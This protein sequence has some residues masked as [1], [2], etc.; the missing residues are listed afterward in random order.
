MEDQ[1]TSNYRFGF[2]GKGLPRRM[3]RR[4]HGRRTKPQRS[5]DSAAARSPSTRKTSISAATF[6]QML[7]RVIPRAD[8]PQ[9]DRPL[10]WD[11]LPWD[12]A[13]HLMLF[14]HRVEGLPPGL[15]VSSA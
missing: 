7:H 11:A 9:L 8:R 2:T 10:P 15:Y 4:F 5:S 6:F 14:V 12:P 1:S 3:P 13:I